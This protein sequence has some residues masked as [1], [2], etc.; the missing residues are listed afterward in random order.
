M[1]TC[2]VFHFSM[3]LSSCACAAVVSPVVPTSRIAVDA[4]LHAGLLQVGDDRAVHD[5][6]LGGVAEHRDRLALRVC[7]CFCDELDQDRR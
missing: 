3:K 7:F 4:G 2:S 5:A 1:S 6:R